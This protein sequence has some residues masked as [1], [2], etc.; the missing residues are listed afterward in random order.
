MLKIKQTSN[1]VTIECR[2]TP[3]A[4]RSA[5]KGVKNGILQ[6]ALSAPPSEGRA[7]DE[8]IEVFAD[9]LRIPKSRIAILK[10]HHS[11]NKVVFIQG[12]T[13]GAVSQFITY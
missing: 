3:R 7:N 2:V 8:L 5:I 11:R 10:G 4:G 6:V 9:A 12:I 1:G 13:K